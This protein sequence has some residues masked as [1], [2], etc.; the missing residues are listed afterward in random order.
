MRA[1][2]AVAAECVVGIVREDMTTGAPIRHGDVQKPGGVSV[3]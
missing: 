3:F 2:A 1:V